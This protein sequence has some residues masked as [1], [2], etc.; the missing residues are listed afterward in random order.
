[1]IGLF[2]ELGPCGV[3]INGKPYNN[4]YSWSEESNM[5][6]IDQ[7]AQVG[8]SYTKTTPATVDPES[9]DVVPLS[10]PKCPANE[11]CGT[12]SIPD[13]STTANSTINAA[14]NF[15]KT[16]QGFMGAF[17]QYSRNGFHFTTESYGGHY[18]PIFSEYIEQQNAKKIKDAHEIHLESVNIGNGWFDPILQYQ[19]YYNWALGNTYDIK[20]Y[21]QS[22]ANQVRNDLYGKGKCLD[23]LRSCAA[24]GNNTICSEGDD[25]CFYQIEYPFDTSSNRD[26]YDARELMPDPFPYEFYVNYLNTPH[27][28]KS[29]GAYQNFSEYANAVGR[30]F[31]TTGD[32]GREEGTVEAVRKLLSQNV[33]VMLYFGDADY[34]CNWFGGEA[35]A[36]EINAPS[37]AKAGYTKLKTSD[38]ITHGEVKQAGLFS[39]VR[40]YESGHEVPFYQPLASLE[41]FHRAIN[42][43]DIATGQVKIRTG[44]Y[45]DGYRTIGPS[46]S[47]YREGNGT[48]QYEVL[49]VTAHYNTKT[50]KPDPLPPGS[51]KK[52]GKASASKMKKGFARWRSLKHGL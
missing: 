4:P 2:Q 33:A 7:P 8:F 18:A 11:T 9:G 14:E 19:G 52:G 17:P 50:N 13:P 47:T 38:H 35:V 45:G 51:G 3:D 40:I 30:A 41:I 34:N 10:S 44:G 5:I 28:Q 15:W 12:F 37:Y 24:T 48:V 25:F 49:P 46:K 20:I 29:I 23:Q 27:V 22:T 31:G 26:E 21:N 32:D 1:M 42:R 16:L 6:F 43:L 36:N 39:F